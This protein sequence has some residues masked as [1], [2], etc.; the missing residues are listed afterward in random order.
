MEVISNLNRAEGTRK[1]KAVSKSEIQVKTNT[2]A[3]ITSP[4]GV[5]WRYSDN[6]ANNRLIVYSVYFF[7]VL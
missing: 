3:T 4:K 2:M 6:Y 7:P 1:I 5:T